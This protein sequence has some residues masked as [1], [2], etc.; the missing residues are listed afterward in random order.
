VPALANDDHSPGN[1]RISLDDKAARVAT[2]VFSYPAQVKVEVWA[3]AVS[4]FALPAVSV[5][6]L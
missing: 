4:K 3:A 2:T 5:Y 6:I 1:A